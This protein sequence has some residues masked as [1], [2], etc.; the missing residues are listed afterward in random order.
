MLQLWIKG[1][2]IL[3]ESSEEDVKAFIEKSVTCRL[4]CAHRSPILYKLVTSLQQHTCRSSC[5]RK[6]KLNVGRFIHRCRYGF[7]RNVTETIRLNS[8]SESLK[9]RHKARKIM[10]L[11]DL[12][13]R[14]C[15]T[16]VNDYNP[17]LLMLWR[18]N[19]VTASYLSP[20]LRLVFQ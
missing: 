14:N 19:V 7:P 20:Y 18:S 2:P 1:A 9:S 10:K 12:P 17:A 5:L 13:R 8:P 16:N 4:P 3:G 6:V 15:E 11:Y